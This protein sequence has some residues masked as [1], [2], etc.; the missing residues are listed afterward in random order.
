MTGT[1]NPA[2][3]ALER[4]M[5][6]V[7]APLVE[8]F[9][10]FRAG[11]ADRE[12][13]SFEAP[14]YMFFTGGLLHWVFKAL[15][16]LPAEVPLVLLGAGLTDDEKACLAR[17]TGRPF[18]AIETAVDDR[19]A[20]EMLWAVERGPFGW[21]DIDC[22]VLDPDLIREMSQV[23]EGVAFNCL[24]AH[25]TGRGCSLPYP[26]F[27]FV[28]GELAADEELRAIGA[29]PG[30]FRYDAG[31]QG[32]RVPW[33]C[34]R[35]LEG[36]LRAAVDRVIGPPEERDEP[37]FNERPFFEPL[38]VLAMAAYDRGYRLNPVRTLG[39][40]RD[41]D[42]W[43][44]QIVHV[45]SASYVIRPDFPWNELP[46]APRKRYAMILVADYLLATE[47]ADELPAAYRAEAARRRERIEAVAEKSMT[48]EHLRYASRFLMT[49]CVSEERIA[50][51]DR[52]RF[53]R[54]TADPVAVAG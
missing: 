21:L 23:P 37:Y 19:T 40:R 11:L 46:V 49:H 29:T 41:E 50:T 10:R 25:D 52:W 22:F 9:R 38:Q 15:E 18:H 36:E 16:F 43:S 44:E 3:D 32:R 53:V 51:D 17:R 20:W 54:A 33:A 39:N 5:D 30:S 27:V 47:L 24:W 7:Q 6:R 14:L 35:R 13:A 12:G 2:A 8:S 45:S 26:H 31:S 28:G 4:E 48:D 34:N 42:H 1:V